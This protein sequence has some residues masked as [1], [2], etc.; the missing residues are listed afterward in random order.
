MKR[1]FLPG[2]TIGVMGGG[3]L[4]RMFAIAA[5]RMG[6]RVHVFTPDE[7]SPASQFADFTSRADYNDEDAV[8]RF[9]R[10]VKLITFEFE[11]IPAGTIA[12]C[13]HHAELRPSGNAVE[14]AQH[15]LREKTWL[16]D[17]GIPLPEFRPVRSVGDL[18]AAVDQI[19]RA[20]ILKTASWGY[21]GKGQQSISSRDLEEVWAARAGDELV[22]ERAIDFEK[23]I[24]VIV[25]RDPKGNIAAFPVAEN[26]HRNHILDVSIVP[27]DIPKT[28]ADEA[29]KLANAIAEKL[30]LVGLLAVE[31]FVE[32]NGGVLVNE[33]APRPH[34]S[35]HWSI[36][37]CVTS[38]FEQHVRAVCGLPLGA[39]ELLRPTAMA[40]LLGDVWQ[41]GEPDWSAALAVPNVRLHLYGKSEARPRRKMGHLTA[42]AN[43][44]KEAA[45]V[46]R[47]ARK[48]LCKP[49]S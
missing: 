3:Q 25:A 18:E 10:N 9:A 26:I 16:A 15:R 5:R 34:N 1:P 6:Y 44:A 2:N 13:A 42:T 49:K 14:I 17:N 19:G 32:K 46:V 23:E 45:E 35:G 40:N 7:N 33:L 30:N 11:N 29:V 21:D 12:W 47:T 28:I 37:G 48:K 41:N 36:E 8:R 27:A 43:S 24:S 39:T 4:G 22:L 31:M 38:Q 20:A